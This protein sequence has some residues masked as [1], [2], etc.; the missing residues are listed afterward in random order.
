MQISVLGGGYILRDGGRFH[1]AKD[2]H[3]PVL[4]NEVMEYT[5]LQA[6]GRYIDATVGTGG[7]AVGILER[8]A[9]T[10]RLLGL[11]QDPTALDIASERLD[12]FGERVLLVQRNFRFL[13]DVVQQ[14]NFGPVDGILFDLGYSSVQ[15]D[16]HARGFSFRS[17]VP[18]DMRFDPDA[19]TTAEDLVNH[20]PQ[21]KLADL[22]YEYGEERHSRRIAR[23][24]VANR[25]ISTARELADLIEATLGRRERIHPATRTFQALRIAVNDELGALEEALPQA[26]EVLEAGGRLL[27]ISFHSLEDRIVKHFFRRESKDC[28]CPPHI[29]VCECDHVATL[30]IITRK[31]V[32]AS[33]EEIAANPR[34]RSAKLRVAER[35]PELAEI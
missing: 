19:P 8:S 9:P 10:G 33:E 4:Y 1:H 23:A 20:L 24:I 29:L 27:V 13:R 2:N 16:D 35:L 25:P 5:Q 7:H 31:P 21:D 15:I 6:G 17:D 22:I 11:D 34:A 14:H 32:T 26:V 28:I 3:Y 12:H 18:L 30:K